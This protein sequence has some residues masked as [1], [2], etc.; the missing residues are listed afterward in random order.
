MALLPPMCACISGCL[1]YTYPWAD[2]PPPKRQS[3]HKAPS[4]RRRGGQT[5]SVFWNVSCRRY[6]HDAGDYRGV[7]LYHIAKAC[8]SSS[9][10]AL[11]S[12]A[13]N[14]RLH[15]SIRLL[16]VR[17]LGTL[18]MPGP[19]AQSPAGRSSAR[20]T[21][22]CRSIKR[23]APAC[24]D[25]GSTPVTRPALCFDSLGT[26]ASKALRESSPEHG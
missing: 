16:V 11:V 6:H 12:L 3:A 18:S 5:L 19:A 23:C 7:R 13:A 24:A 4:C 26:A 20:A 22:L 17:G 9:F 2:P 15:D 21:P 1:A 25:H 10:A 14:A 8:P